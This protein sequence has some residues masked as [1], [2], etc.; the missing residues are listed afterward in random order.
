MF[1]GAIISTFGIEM[2][3]PYDLFLCC[4]K[5]TYNLKE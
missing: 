3:N 1:S 2:Y 5:A 4:R